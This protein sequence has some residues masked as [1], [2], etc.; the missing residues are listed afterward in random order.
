MPYVDP[1][2]GQEVYD[3]FL[4]PT[5]AGMA[6]DGGP[7]YPEPVSADPLLDYD[8]ALESPPDVNDDRSFLTPSGER[9]RASEMDE[10]QRLHGARSGSSSVS[11]SYRG[12][13]TAG[14]NRVSNFVD[15]RT[16]R[17]YP[18]LAGLSKSLSKGVD[19]RAVLAAEGVN[20]LGAA[21][22][23][24][25][26]AER[27]GAEQTQLFHQQQALDEQRAEA[28][29]QENVMRAK[30]ALQE[31]MAR[32]A[33]MKVDPDRLFKEAGAGGRVGF[34]MAAFAEG[35]LG[36]KG[37]KINAIDQI[38][39]RI[40][41][42]IDAQL[43]D[44]E[45][46]RN[47]TNDFRTLYDIANQ[48]SADGVQARGRMR[49]FYLAS[50]Q[51]D[52][53]AKSLTARGGVEQSQIQKALGELEI[54]K[55]KEADGILSYAYTEG[56]R[57]TQQEIENAQR[58]W[59]LS[60]QSAS[61]KLAQ[62]R[63]DAEKGPTTLDEQ[64]KELRKRALIS[65][66]AEG[67]NRVIA[68]MG[69]GYSPEIRAQL[70]KE[71]NSASKMSAGVQKV[72][73]DLSK[74]K[75]V[76]FTEGTLL[77]SIFNSPE[78]QKYRARMDQIITDYVYE[79]SGKAITSVELDRYKSFLPIDAPWKRTDTKGTMAQFQRDLFD[80]VRK[81]IGGFTEH[82]PQ[83]ILD[84]MAP[85]QSTDIGRADIKA[86]EYTSAPAP[87]DTNVE[88]L[89]KQATS[90]V[91]DYESLSKSDG[92]TARAK[93]LR[94]V[95]NMETTAMAGSI[96]ALAALQDIGTG[97]G[98]PT[99]YVQDAAWAAYRRVL[100]ATE[101]GRLRRQDGPVVETVPEPD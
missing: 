65:T 99:K 25:T 100:K 87:A 85:G 67:T 79:K 91:R 60:I 76:V 36:A 8:A 47:A 21:Q 17:E 7:V 16:S 3:P 46:G 43:T 10:Y 59:G 94:G 98:N 83:E 40:D 49:M 62:A 52:L 53:L 39:R 45:Q 27:L 4:E 101:E 77:G 68:V 55:S 44:I 66:D 2:T 64:L 15:S 58:N 72:L 18:D 5:N 71:V 32:V 14:A 82:M 89:V 13:S 30:G 61:Q 6:M 22:A 42:D 34:A 29:A 78:G 37:I 56:Q 95:E 9:I 20:A 81:D 51:Q 50:L 24:A 86:A 70:Q 1:V 90:P 28:L 35:F 69:E 48:E 80:N 26:E 19:E 23:A 41:R 84:R 63:F 92:K 54:A 57:R 31:Q 97:G 88:G 11:T 33:A 93:R 73:E 75:S 12:G 38:N 74:D 96:D